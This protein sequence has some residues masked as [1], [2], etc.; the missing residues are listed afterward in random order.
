[1]RPGAGAKWFDG[2]DT[3]ASFFHWIEREAPTPSPGFVRRLNAQMRS[4]SAWTPAQ[5]TSINA[6]GKTVD[7]LWSEYVAAT[8]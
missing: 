8:A 5:I 3:T 4:S 1:M 7:A 6:R 2:Y